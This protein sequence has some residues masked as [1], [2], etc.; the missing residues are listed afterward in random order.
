MMVL[1]RPALVS[2]VMQCASSDCSLYAV[3]GTCT[4]V[5]AACGVLCEAFPIRDLVSLSLYKEQGCNIISGDLYI[6]E[7]PIDVSKTTLT[8]ALGS[9]RVIQGHLYIMHNEYLT[10][11]LFLTGLQRVEGITYLNNPIL[12]D[13]RI[14]SLQS[15]DFTTVVEG[16][17]RLCPARY[18]TL[19]GPAQDQSECTDPGVRY[20]LGVFDYAS[21]DDLDVL[22][23]L[24]ARVL[25]L[26][27]DR[28][29]CTTDW[30]VTDTHRMQWNG[31]ASVSVIEFGAGWWHVVV[32]TSAI[33][34]ETLNA[35][36]AVYDMIQSKRLA[37]F[38]IGDRERVFLARH[39]VTTVA[40]AQYFV[41]PSV[42]YHGS[43][44]LIGV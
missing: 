30:L 6:I 26:R 20:Y 23:A 35:R 41:S 2:D 3:D 12:V 38:A 32:E 18:T 34:P 21:R 13:A 10:A 39:R 5:C 33:D 11:M 36:R 7:L 28:P 42:G 8:N 16:C 4:S 29:V 31:S 1:P 19:L 44:A 37:E 24:V 27:A 9:V 22:A 14:A 17:P 25:H 40:G 15:N 43:N